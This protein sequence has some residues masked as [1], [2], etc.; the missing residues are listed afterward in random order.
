MHT[1]TAQLGDIKKVHEQANYINAVLNAIAEQLS[2]LNAKTDSKKQ[3][4][5]KDIANS[6]TKPSSSFAESISK[7]LS[8]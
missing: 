4:S 7:P 8:N 5:K 2:Q 1:D 3:A 6:N